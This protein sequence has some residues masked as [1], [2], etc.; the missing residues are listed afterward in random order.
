MV[1]EKSYPAIPDNLAGLDLHTVYQIKYKPKKSLLYVTLSY[2]TPEIQIVWSD[3]G[4]KQRNNAKYQLHYIGNTKV[5]DAFKPEILVKDIHFTKNE[6][7]I[8]ISPTPVNFTYIHDRI[9]QDIEYR[10]KKC[11]KITPRYFTD[12]LEY[13]EPEAIVKAEK[14][15]D[16][17]NA[18]KT[19]DPKKLLAKTVIAINKLDEKYHFIDTIERE[20]IFDKLIEIAQKQNITSD[21]ATQI[22][23]ENRDW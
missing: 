5:A 18:N 19:D 15:I 9:E 17:L 14:I 21:V 3:G 23:D 11:L 7:D 6:D 2:D 16:K 10:N 22:I 20:N 13:V 12:W 4:Y 1:F 8:I